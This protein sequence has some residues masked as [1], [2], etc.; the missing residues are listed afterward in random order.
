MI[1]LAKFTVPLGW[2]VIFRRTCRQI[3]RGHCFGWAAALAY[4]SFLA[5]FPALLFVV[6]VAAPHCLQIGTKSGTFSTSKPK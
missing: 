6:S 3:Y 4:Y 5:L 1:L 2:P